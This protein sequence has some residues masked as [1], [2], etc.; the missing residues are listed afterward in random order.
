MR[1]EARPAVCAAVDPK[2]L[3]E[4]AIRLIAKPSPTGSAGAAS[5]ELAAVLKEKGYNARP[6]HAGLTSEE[7]Q[8]TQDDFAAERVDLIV[9]TVA[10]GMGI[11][12][13]DV[14]CPEIGRGQRLRGHVA[15]GSPDFLGVVLDPTRLGENLAEFLLC[16]TQDEPIAPECDCPGAGSALV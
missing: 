1:T 7:R 2:R 10:F 5:D 6:Y 9:A 15:L 13:G 8:N 4:T 16:S 11:D 14:R 12:R 3:L